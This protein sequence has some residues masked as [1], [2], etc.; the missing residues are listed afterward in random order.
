MAPIVQVPFMSSNERFENKETFGIPGPGT[1]NPKL[2]ISI[3][4]PQS[5]M[6]ATKANFGVNSERFKIDDEVFFSFKIKIP[7][8]INIFF[9]KRINL[10]LELILIHF[11]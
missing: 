5:K 1:Y 8:F 9:K 11:S 2:K 6:L 10:G 4:N 3:K 7:F